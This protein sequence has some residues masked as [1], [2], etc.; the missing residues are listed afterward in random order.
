MN[1]PKLPDDPIVFSPGKGEGYLYLSS[2]DKMYIPYCPFRH[3]Y[4]GECIG[5]YDSPADA[6]TESARVYV[7]K[8]K[9]CSPDEWVVDYDPDIN[10]GMVMREINTTNI[11]DGLTS[12]YKWNQ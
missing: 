6:Y 3:E 9:G 8:F 12:E 10:E 7:Y 4:L 5:Y 11:P 1:T 2:G